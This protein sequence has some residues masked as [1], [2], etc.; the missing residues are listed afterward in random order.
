MK[1]Q[2]LGFVATTLIA[3]SALAGDNK[4]DY[5]LTVSLMSEQKSELIGAVGSG[6]N[7]AELVSLPVKSHQLYT[8]NGMVFGEIH[9]TAK[10]GYS[11]DQLA[12]EPS[13]VPV[14]V[15]FEVD[16]QWSDVNDE[17][18]VTAFAAEIKDIKEV[19]TLGR[20]SDDCAAESVTK[21]GVKA[22][23]NV[24]HY[25]PGDLVNVVEVGNGYKLKFELKEH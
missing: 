6:G 13:Q 22:S 18:L 12:M 24:H 14:F 9:T 5:T 8:Y 10:C 21:R 7:E 20:I 4:P 19:T 17:S 15:N 2:I 16:G 11:G 23:G 3:S 1:K 25:L